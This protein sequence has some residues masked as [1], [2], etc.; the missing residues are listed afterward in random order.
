MKFLSLNE[1]IFELQ[2]VRDQIA[3][4]DIY[5]HRCK[6]LV[7]KLI[8]V[9]KHVLLKVMVGICVLRM[10]LVPLLMVYIFRS[11]FVLRDYV[12][13]LVTIKPIGL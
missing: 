4:A 6:R 7:F 2:D 12:L 9:I 1:A 13:M 3:I 8:N 11:L 5:D 10:F